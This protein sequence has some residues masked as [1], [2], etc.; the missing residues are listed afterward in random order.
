M[1]YALSILI[2]DYVYCVMT[3]MASLKSIMTHNQKAT[4]IS[5]LDAGCMFCYVSGCRK[6]K[7][8]SNIFIESKYDSNVNHHISRTI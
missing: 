5:I 8:D 1:C 4:L 2:F 3:D 7:V 6:D